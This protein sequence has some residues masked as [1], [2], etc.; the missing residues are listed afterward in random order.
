MSSEEKKEVLFTRNST[1]L[2]RQ[3]RWFDSFIFNSSSSWMFGTL[4]LA[5]SSLAWLKGVDLISAEGIALLFAIAIAVM[6]AILT[7]MMPRSGG[8][9]VFNSRILHPSIGFSFNFSLSVW[10]LFSAAF[11]L[12]FIANVA[13]SPGLEVLGYYANMQ[14]L[15]QVGVW[16]SNPTNAFIVATIVNILFTLVTLTGIRRTFTSLDVLWGITIFGTIVM[17]VSLLVTTPSAFHAAFNSFMTNANGTS[18]SRDAFTSVI[19]LGAPIPPVYALAFP[20]VAIVADSVIWVF[21]ETYVSGEVRHANQAKRN[22]STMVGAAVLNAAFFVTLAYL[23]Y[24]RVGVQFLTALTNLSNVASP[25]TPFGSSLQALTT[26]L[27]L[28]TGNFYAALILVVAITLGFSVLLL[29]ALYLQPIRSIFAWSFDRIFPDRFNSVSSRFHTPLLTTLTVFVLIEGA[30]VLITEEYNSLLGIFFAVIV[31]PA[32]SCIFPTSLSA[33][34]AGLRARRAGTV[35]AQIS[36]GR[37]YI[38][39]LLGILSLSFISYMTYVFVTNEQFFF[40]TSTFLSPNTLI[41]LNFVF[42]PIGALIYFA[43]YQFRKSRNKIN[44]NRIAMEIPPE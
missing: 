7:A 1:G 5:L 39:T 17:I 12:F 33:I 38:I 34:V 28:A 27:I 21:W 25:A 29:P 20:A 23:L 16:F 14:W 8:D 30:L 26:V 3:G 32:F 31:A 19:Q 42:I 37:W 4:I 10:Q 44:I 41:A 36:I 15:N 40:A 18:T 13:L 6:Y 11:T 24:S 43:S 35:R 2:V 9:Y 22:I